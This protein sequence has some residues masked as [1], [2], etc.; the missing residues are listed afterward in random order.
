MVKPKSRRRQQ[1]RGEEQEQTA[2]EGPQ[3]RLNGGISST[4]APSASPLADGVA[5]LR[6]G[7][8]AVPKA[9]PG[10][11]GLPLVGVKVIFSKNAA[12]LFHF[13]CAPAATSTAPD[14]RHGVAS[15][16]SQ[17]IPI[18]QQAAG[19]RIDGVVASREPQLLE[20][21]S[22][23]LVWLF[24]HESTLVQVRREIRAARI[25]RTALRKHR[26][27]TPTHDVVG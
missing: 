18:G 17:D 12:C 24:D 27:C 16:A 20:K 19:R 3:P 26:K 22:Q 15:D 1:L 7:T 4:H 21:E 6:L 5:A 11:V 25:A 9:Y 8:A 13:S 10:P 23:L 2:A 14:Q